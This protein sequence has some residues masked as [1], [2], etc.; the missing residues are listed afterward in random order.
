[1]TV[2]GDIVSHTRQAHTDKA[3][4]NIEKNGWRGEWWSDGVTEWWSGGVVEFFC[5]TAMTLH[6]FVTP[7]L[8]HSQTFGYTGVDITLLNYSNDRPYIMTEKLSIS[9]KPS[10]A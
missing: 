7:S 3:V 6:H 4:Y 5:F 1:M 10:F 9:Y 2:I 8:R